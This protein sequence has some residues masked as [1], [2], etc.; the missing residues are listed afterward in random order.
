MKRKY[1]ISGSD[2]AEVRSLAKRI[3]V[4]A[5]ES[6]D[7]LLKAED[8]FQVADSIQCVYGGWDR[9]FNDCCN[10]DMGLYDLQRSAVVDTDRLAKKLLQQSQLTVSHIKCF[11][12][13]LTSVDFWKSMVDGDLAQHG[14]IT[15]STDV[16]R[17]LQNVQCFKSNFVLLDEVDILICLSCT[18][19]SAWCAAIAAS[20]I[21][22]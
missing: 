9:I 7:Q 17:V 2:V 16:T 22:Y 19:H 6:Q 5:G 21:T 1:N 15:A 3:K 14:S 11:L 20:T 12:G 10:I 18:F 13:Q 8:V 4:H